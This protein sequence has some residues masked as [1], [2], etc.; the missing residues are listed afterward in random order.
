M[1][2]AAQLANDL[3]QV[4]PGATATL[5]VEVANRSDQPTAFDVTVEGL[6]PSWVAV[7]VAHFTLDPR[8]VRS[9]RIF[10][11]PPRETESVAGTYPF[12]LNVRTLETG[13]TK[14]MPCVLE[15][16][17]FHNFSVDVQPRRASVSPFARDTQFEVTV[18]NLGNSEQTMQMFA[19]DPEGLFAFEFDA[20]QVLLGPGQQR[21]LSL[22]ASATRSALLA[23]S[24][25]AN[26]SVS[27]RSTANPAVAAASTAQ[28]E[29]KALATPGAFLLFLLVL[30][31]AAAW[32]ALWPKAPTIESLTV[33][34]N[35]VQVGHEVKIE[36]RTANARQVKVRIGSEFQDRLPPVGST[37][38]TPQQA[39]DYVVE[40]LATNGQNTTRDDTERIKVTEA[41]VIPEPRI[42]ELSTEKKELA[43][44][45][46][47]T[48]RY[49]FAEGVTRATLMPMQRELDVKEDGILLGA[50]EVGKI[51]LTVKAYNEAGAMVER[52]VSVSVVKKSAA[53]IVKFTAGP[54]ELT[55]PGDVTVDWTV[56]DAARIELEVGEQRT[57][58]TEP[59]G[60][61][62]I[63]VTA[64]TKIRIVA[65][66][67][68][69]L[70]VNSDV[71]TIKVKQLPPPPETTGG[72]AGE[73][74]ENIGGGTTG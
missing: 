42:L 17:S 2:F 49:K 37:T 51:D 40:V 53:R 32:L 5:A 66:D 10:I 1:S 69:G 35:T 46:K 58:L 47:F 20:D 55:G 15:V 25:L 33:T 23:N 45:E 8:E 61:R 48:L 21:S 68:D 6:D 28:I 9:E 19:T 34:P 63:S 59:T 74:G 41:P 50:D 73:A 30:G 62:L 67:R 29:Q 72:T 39:G 60:T 14:S 54:K 12:V 36:W 52:T 64:D 7:P 16:K 27:A 38:F 57:L 70:A 71:V 65:L 4:D 24:R 44:G 22:S 56:V 31:L 18:M 43:L 13:E 26:F 3:V 11:K